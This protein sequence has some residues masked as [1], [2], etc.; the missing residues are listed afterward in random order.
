MCH[1]WG[2][3]HNFSAAVYCYSLLMVIYCRAVDWSPFLRS[4]PFRCSH[5]ANHRYFGLV[6]IAAASTHLLPPVP[7]LPQLQQQPTQS[8][9]QFDRYLPLEAKG[10][11]YCQNWCH[12][13]RRRH[14]SSPCQSAI[15]YLRAGRDSID[16]FLLLQLLILLLLLLILL[17]LILLLRLLLLLSLLLLL[18]LL[19]LL[20][21]L[22]LRLAVL[23]LLRRPLLRLLY[24]SS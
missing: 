21:L 12:L 20:V 19:L 10:S 4:S 8:Q 11:A 14:R 16:P 18:L 7:P 15:C 5:F 17:L 23:L 3:F 24:S 6:A 1:G 22:L 2:S 13:L 9:S